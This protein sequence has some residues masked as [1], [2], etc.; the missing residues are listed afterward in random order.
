MVASEF[1]EAFATS[2]GWSEKAAKDADLGS[3]CA[4]FVGYA[5][6]Y[7]AERLNSDRPEL[8]ELMELATPTEQ[9][10]MCAYGMASFLLIAGID[11]DHL[12]QVTI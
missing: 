11:V 2:M 3:V 10:T 1:V 7:G 6:V 9:A 8:A 4:Q 5:K 12:P